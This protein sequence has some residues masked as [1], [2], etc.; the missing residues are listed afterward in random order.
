MKR[1]ELHSSTNQDFT[2]TQREN[3]IFK[4]SPIKDRAD[5]VFIH[6]THKGSDAKRRKLHARKT[7]LFHYRGTVEK[8][9]QDI[10]TL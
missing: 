5:R 7:I 6:S 4:N 3:P 10:Q 8:E 2:L 9:T 1:L